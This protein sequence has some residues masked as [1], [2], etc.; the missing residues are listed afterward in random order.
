[1]EKEVTEAERRV[2]IKRKYSDKINLLMN[3]EIVEK[4]LYLLI[5]N[6]FADFLKLEY[7]FTYEELSQE[8]N[9]VFVRQGLKKN[10]DKMLDDMS[11]L[12]YMP[13]HDLTQEEKKNIL[14]NFSELM[15]QLIIDVEEKSNKSSFFSKL[16]GINK[17]LQKQERPELYKDKISVA[18]DV[19]LNSDLPPIQDFD[20]VEQKDKEAK[21][22][23]TPFE[24]KKE[25]IKED[26][27]EFLSQKV[28]EDITKS[29]NLLLFNESSEN[30]SDAK[31]HK[32]NNMSNIIDY[33]KNSRNTDKKSNIN[34]DQ[35]SDTAN[36]FKSSSSSV[37]VEENDSA[38]IK[39]R[40]LI[41]ESYLQINL[42][43]TLSAKEKYIN[44]L[45][46][47]DAFSYEQKTKTYLD[48]YNLYLKL[49]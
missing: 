18:N 27:A 33:K 6:F 20:Y 48:M 38:I 12:E 16:F 8:L 26:S 11:R 39:I 13:N 4:E 10:I 49:K 29:N 28:T 47:Y 40:S 37:M 3:A 21:N 9:K 23:K 45:S 31:T 43:N 19:N 46:M 41:E 1:M 30:F 15:N 5:R 42:N 36:T 17:L 14:A 7:E 2:L 24:L 44:A 22:N 32:R 35:K 25:I 34:A